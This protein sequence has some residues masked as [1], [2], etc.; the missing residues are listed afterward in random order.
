MSDRSIP[1]SD[2]RKLSPSFTS[3]W[4]SLS[5]PSSSTLVLYHLLRLCFHTL[6]PYNVVSRPR[7]V[8]VSSSTDSSAS[9]SLKMELLSRYGY[10]SQLNKT[11]NSFFVFLLSEPSSF[12]VQYQFVPFKD[13][14]LYHLPPPPPS[15]SYYTSSTPS[16]SPSMSSFKSP[17]SS[18]HLK[19]DGP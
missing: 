2:V 7:H 8:G 9:N 13:G 6:S 3:S 12:Q 17:S 14:L 11:N 5:F 18:T 10:L 19:I 1:L 4:L 16:F 15:S